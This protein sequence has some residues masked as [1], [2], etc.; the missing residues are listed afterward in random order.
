MR[1]HLVDRIGNLGHDCDIV[2]QLLAR[3]KSVRSRPS[4]LNALLKL[5]ESERS[6]ILRRDEPKLRSAEPICIA[7][8]SRV[9]SGRSPSSR[10]K[11]GAV[12]RGGSPEGQSWLPHAPDVRLDEIQ[13]S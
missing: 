2:G 8:M 12:I 11:L 4:H 7:I 5:G 1:E 10:A 6:L 9:I 3:S 13:R